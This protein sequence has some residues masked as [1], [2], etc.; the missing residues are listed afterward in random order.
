MREADGLRSARA[1]LPVGIALLTALAC[2]IVPSSDRRGDELVVVARVVAGDTLQLVSGEQVRLIGV[3]A[4][5]MA[6]PQGGIERFGR[7]SSEFT[8][9]LVEGNRVRLEFDQQREDRHGRTLA[10]AYLEDGTLVNAE[11]I[12]QGYGFAYTRFPFRQLE[13]FQRLESE[14]REA[15]RG[16]WAVSVAPDPLPEMVWPCP[17]DRQIKANM[18]GTGACIYHVPA[19][20][21]YARTTPDQCF[22]TEAEASAAGCRR[23]K[24]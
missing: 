8:A 4:P 19:A 2:A 22:A 14:A 11:V 20:R 16:L 6:N 12:R 17:E 18:R 3:D 10:Y 13:E 1:R 9:R 7:E 23:S 5:G 24:L 15:E 21:S